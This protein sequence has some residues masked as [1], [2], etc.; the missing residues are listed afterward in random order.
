MYEISLSSLLAISMTLFII[1][2]LISVNIH[3]FPFVLYMWK[4][5]LVAVVILYTSLESCVYTI[6]MW[7]CTYVTTYRKDF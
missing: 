2:I 5:T 7:A 4:G 6:L 1:V 3:I